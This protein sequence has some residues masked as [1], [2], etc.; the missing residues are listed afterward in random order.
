[1]DSILRLDLTIG[2]EEHLAGVLGPHDTE[3]GLVT[4][5]VEGEQQ[6]GFEVGTFRVQGSRAAILAWLIEEWQDFE[7]ALDEFVDAIKEGR[8]T[9]A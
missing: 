9:A 7:L 2:G 1:M 5:T 3:N 6:A 4:V 8:L